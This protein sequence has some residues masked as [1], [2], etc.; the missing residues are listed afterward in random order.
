MRTDELDYDLPADRIATVA[1]EPRDAA[2]L[3][4]VHRATQRVEH[5]HV[6]DLPNLGLLREGDLLVVNQTRVLPAFI[7]ATR[8]A[9]GGNVTGLY[10]QS[11]PIGQWQVML[12]SRGKLQPGETLTFANGQTMSLTRSLGQGQWEAATDAKLSDVGQTP[13][14][15]YIRKARQKLGITCVSDDDGLRYNT[16]YAADP[17][18]IAA[19]TAGLHFTCELIE[20]LEAMGVMRSAVTLHVGVGT[21]MPVRTATLEAHVMHREMTRVP[22]ETIRAICATRAAGGRIIPV[23]TTTVRALESLPD[24]IDTLTG[25]YVADTNLFI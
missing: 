11:T 24:P 12:E 19:P 25:D 15:P 6:R 7:T 13:L 18:S 20:Q 22:I 16:V 2:R 17:G 21:F 14:P 4:V 23:G 5:C 10:L 8:T 1:A 9:T 3:M